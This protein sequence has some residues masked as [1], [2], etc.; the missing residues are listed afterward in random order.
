MEKKL[1]EFLPGGT[2]ADVPAAR[3]RSM[4]L[5]RG[6]NNR[7]TERLLRMAL[8]RSGQR[9]WLMHYG[10]PGKP[11]FYFPTQRV[12]VFVDGCF[13][14]GCKRCGHVPK[15]RS[16]FWQAKLRRNRQRDRRVTHSLKA[17]GIEVIRIW[18]HCL[19]TS[20]LVDKALVAIQQLLVK[21][22]QQ[23][24]NILGGVGIG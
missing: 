1:K 6:R 4:S 3:S 8:V 21:E 5:I 24:C 16:E 14:H 22:C 7:T 19:K 10:L 15:T 18:E 11:D 12:A 20:A 9:G 2:F 17:Q 23:A 13:W